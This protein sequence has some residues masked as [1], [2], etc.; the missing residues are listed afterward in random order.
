M[1]SQSSG[2]PC[3]EVFIT[4]VKSFDS[5]TNEESITT[6]NLESK[7]DLEFALEIIGMFQLGKGR[8]GLTNQEITPDELQGIFDVIINKHC[9][10]TPGL[11]EEAKDIY[12]LIVSLISEPFVIDQTGAVR[13][14]PGVIEVDTFSVPLIPSVGSF[15]PN[16]AELY[17]RALAHTEMKLK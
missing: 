13:N 12:E 17:Y 5:G 8:R 15:D 9:S 14:F 11:A 1:F 10:I 16:K 6:R 2:Q 4:V 7:E 3:G